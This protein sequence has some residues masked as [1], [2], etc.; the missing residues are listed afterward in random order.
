MGPPVVW[1][2][3][4]EGDELIPGITIHALKAEGQIDVYECFS[5]QFYVMHDHAQIYQDFLDRL[6]RLV[7]TWMAEAGLPR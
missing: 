6:P 2:L 4:I 5:S 1:S 7:E 3:K